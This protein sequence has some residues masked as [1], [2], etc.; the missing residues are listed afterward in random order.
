VNIVLGISGSIAAY[1]AADLAS[2]LAKQGH[3]VHAVMTRSA[4]EFITPLTLQTLT[5][6]PVL[7][8]L[9][10]E[11]NSWKPGHIE[12]ADKA[13]LLLLAPAS[14]NLLGHLAN[15]LAPDPLSSVY[16]ALPRSTPVLIAPAMNGKMWLHPATGRNLQALRDDGVHVIDPES[17]L[18][19]DGAVGPGRLAEPV[20]IVAGGEA[21]LAGVES[22]RVSGAMLEFNKQ[23]NAAL[24]V[25]GQLAS[26]SREHLEKLLLENAYLLAR[27]HAPNVGL[28]S[29]A[30]NLRNVLVND[31]M[32]HPTLDANMP[33]LKAPSKFAHKLKRVLSS[34]LVALGIGQYRHLRWSGPARPAHIH[35]KRNAPIVLEPP[36]C[37]SVLLKE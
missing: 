13:D 23:V 8:T 27:L 22:E 17:G 32:P 24:V 34:N 30:W 9:E 37:G 11:K 4:T 36:E 33:R 19:A 18:L 35:F 26:V 20:S 2:Q 29:H 1:K 15:G 6:Q 31:F 10:D 12:L 5:R 25:L 7:V 14:A 16:L 28:I 3:E 21:V